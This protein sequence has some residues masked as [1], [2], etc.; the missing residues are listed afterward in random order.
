MEHPI[1]NSEQH[2][3]VIA[4]VTTFTG[5]AAKKKKSPT[6]FAPSAASTS[7]SSFVWAPSN[8]NAVFLTWHLQSSKIK[9]FFVLKMYLLCF[10]NNVAVHVYKLLHNKIARLHK[11]CQQNQQKCI[12]GVY[13][14]MIHPLHIYLHHSEKATIM[15][16]KYKDKQWHIKN[17]LFFWVWWKKQFISTMSSS[18]FVYMRRQSGKIGKYAIQ[19]LNMVYFNYLHI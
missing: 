10:T 8:F 13:K 7:S 1:H 17:L 18:Q 5:G 9:M 3:I 14:Y 2:L 6:Q 15:Y 16:S 19:T 12:F 4:S 11:W